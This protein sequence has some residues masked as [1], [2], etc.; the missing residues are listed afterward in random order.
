ML[1][2]FICFTIF[3]ATFLLT[4]NA[5]DTS[6]QPA[7]VSGAVGAGSNTVF[8]PV[9]LPAT[10]PQF[11]DWHFPED[12]NRINAWTKTQD[13]KAIYRHAWGLWEALTAPSGQVYKGSELM[14]FETWY[15]PE[16]VREMLLQPGVTPQRDTRH[17]F[18]KL[19]QL[20]HPRAAD[21]APDQPVTGFVKWNPALADH[22]LKNKLLY[23][24]VLDSLRKN[25][26]GREADGIPAFPGN[27]VAVKPIFQVLNKSQAPEMAP[28]IF[29]VPAW[30]GTPQ[31][32]QVFRNHAWGYF[33]YVDTNNKKSG[34]KNIITKRQTYTPEATYGLGDFI[35]LQA[36]EQM[37]AELC[38]NGDSAKAGDYLILL[39]M[40]IATKESRRWTWQTIYWSHSP[41]DPVPPASPAT[42]Q[43]R[44]AQFRTPAAKHYA[45]AAAYS[46]VQPDQPY[47]G[48]SGTAA[49][50]VYAFNPWLEAGFDKSVLRLP[51]SVGG[52]Q[53]LY[54]VQ[55]N[56]M[57]CHAYASY[58]GAFDTKTGK[59]RF[60][61]ADRYVDMRSD[62]VFT[63]LRNLQTDFLWSIQGN[64]IKEK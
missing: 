4:M 33:I 63:R 61:T 7:G 42:V 54:G 56:C 2:R 13:L 51:A 3:A 57:S 5:C 58:P 11:S 29:R 50:P 41:T 34:G 15:T 23:A 53:Q 37:A 39:G 19:H 17:N 62:S 14:V 31:M 16:D 59:Q 43:E 64:V 6:Q 49:S 8:T 45:L 30:P 18:Q 26:N 27:S 35:Y 47:T 10:H 9:E 46:M 25:L 32:A 24:S 1:Q 52:K 38:A 21:D 40:H 12:S 55:S 44:P 22:V 36:D 60:Y 28:G 20:D 48:G